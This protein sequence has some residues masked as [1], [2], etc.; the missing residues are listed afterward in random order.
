MDEARKLAAMHATKMSRAQ[1][2]VK[3]TVNIIV[4]FKTILPIVFLLG[5]SLILHVG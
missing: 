5:Y 3:V 4:D 1:K 2:Q